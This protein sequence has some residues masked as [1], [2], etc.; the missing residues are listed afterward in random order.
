MDG[1]ALRPTRQTDL[2]FVL[3]AER[4]PDNAP[5]VSQWSRKQHENAIASKNDAHFIV[6]KT[7]VGMNP[8]DQ[9]TSALPASYQSIQSIGY[10]ILVGLENSHL[11]LLLKRIVILPKGQGF[12]RKVLRWIKAFTFEQSGYHR[13]ELDVVAS[14]KRAQHLYRSEGFV[15]EGRLRKAYKTPQGYE[16]LLLLS[17]LKTEYLSAQADQPE[18]PA[19]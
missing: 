6:E 4:H 13:L 7:T 14:N 3:A 11:S 19:S 10:V 12:G 2:K 8:E 16:D 18:Q 1:I 9:S 5:Y 17:I 15:D